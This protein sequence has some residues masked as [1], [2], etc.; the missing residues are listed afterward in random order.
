M[1]LEDIL[2]ARRG[3]KLFLLGNEAAVRAAIES[4]VGVASTYWNTII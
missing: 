1:E 4:G 2:N 3:D